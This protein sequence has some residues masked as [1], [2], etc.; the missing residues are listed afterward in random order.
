VVNLSE[1]S[2][3]CGVPQLIHIP[4][5]HT[6]VVCNLLDQNFYVPPF[7]ATY[8]TLKALVRTWSPRF[9]PFL[10]AEQWEPC[11]GPR[12]VIDNAMMWKKRGPRRRARCAMEM[13]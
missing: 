2:C 8:N 3:T 12:Y 1:N 6:I 5:P 11:D 10:D 9:V 13:D 7:M 4:C